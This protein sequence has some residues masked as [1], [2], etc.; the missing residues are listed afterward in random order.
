MKWGGGAFCKNVE[1]EVFLLK[2]WKIGGCFFVK[3]WTFPQRRVH[4][5]QYQYFF[6]LHYTYLGV[7]RTPPLPTGL[8]MTC[9]RRILGYMRLEIGCKIGLP[10]D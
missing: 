2:K 7:Q 4:Y 9:L 8:I 6:I 10:G 1:N 3:K 5:V